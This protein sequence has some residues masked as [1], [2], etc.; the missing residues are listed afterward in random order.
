[1]DAV[2]EALITGAGILWKA[3]WALIFGYFISASIQ[4]LVTR[5]QMSRALG[6]PGLKQGMLAGFFGFVSSSCSFAALAAAR[7]IWVK[8][9]HPRN[10]LA[11]LVAST[12]LVVELG[13]V[14][15]ILLGW[16]FVLGNFLLGAL[17]I[18][19]MYLLT[20]LWFPRRLAER[21]REHAEQRQNSEQ[22][23]Q[24]DSGESL[25]GDW[26]AKLRS[27]AGWRAIADAFFMEWRMAYK[28][29]LFGFTIAGFIAV[30]V[31]DHAWAALFP[32]PGGSEPSIWIVLQHAA[33]APVAAFFTFIGSM[34]N[35]PLAALLW[36]KHVAFGGVMAFLGADLVAATVLYVQAK[37]YGFRYTA[38]IAA[39][40][41]VSMVVAGLL[42]HA[43]F[44]AF[45]ML[46]SAR[47]QLREQV[48]FA[49]D[50]TF[51]LNVGF[52]LLAGA[53]LW[54]HLRQSKR[55]ATA[56]AHVH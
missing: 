16:E 43:L 37:Y 21:A 18:L 36:S 24:H 52:G 30:F 33:L 29:I 10:S 11:F 41:Y 12:N 34:G 35:V 27:A 6:R 7:A 23:T 50:Y 40:L 20:Q 42:V 47:P 3:L 54:L 46:P 26:T 32:R 49:I 51:W 39:I 48:R 17:M 1:M 2:L 44:V 15:W 28:E 9:A 55:R 45:D 4:V 56:A 25:E 5:K 13:I 14:L 19:S 31:P 38:I 8:G 22:T 53:L